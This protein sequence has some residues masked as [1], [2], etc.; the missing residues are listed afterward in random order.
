[1]FY[2]RPSG[3]ACGPTLA[4][5]CKY[6]EV[7]KTTG[8]AAWIDRFAAW[9]GNITT[10]VTTDTAV[11]TGYQNTIAIVTDN[12]TANKAG[13]LTRAYR[14]PNNLDDWFLPSLDELN[15]L[16]KWQKGQSTSAA[17]QA[18]VCSTSFNNNVGLGAS[19]FD[20]TD[21]YWSSSETALDRAGF[22]YMGFAG[23]VTGDSKSNDQY[24]V[25]SIRAVG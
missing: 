8:T 5:T 6:L 10:S 1:V 18:V 9:S 3:F 11:G 17:D 23:A 22:L 25:R 2:Y 16:C 14:G 20:S 24:S 7:A 13:T 19:G 21:G 4:A 12:S 15:Q